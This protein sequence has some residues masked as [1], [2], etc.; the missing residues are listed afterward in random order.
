MK[1]Q[2]R[3]ND[4]SFSGIVI[5]TIVLVISIFF[6]IRIQLPLKALA[7]NSSNANLTGKTASQ[8]AES[9]MR[10]IIDPQSIISS[11]LNKT[12]NNPTTSTAFDNIKNATSMTT[13]NRNITLAKQFNDN[14]LPVAKKNNE[15]TMENSIPAVRQS[16]I[17]ILAHQIIPPK[18]FIPLYDTTL[19]KITN[20][21]IAAKIPCNG[22]FSST[23]QLFIGHASDIKQVKLEPIKQLS[24]PGYLCMYHTDIGSTHNSFGDKTNSTKITNILLL[25]PSDYRVILPNT[26]TIIIDVNEIMPFDTMQNKETK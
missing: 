17:L 24:K 12:R 6:L 14:A 10:S 3:T 4:K 22:N 20:V 21:H 16:A 8:S 2:Q 19:Y 13:S 25:N 7:E 1:R 11:I 26:S 9:L 5:L 18:D 15:T 23:L